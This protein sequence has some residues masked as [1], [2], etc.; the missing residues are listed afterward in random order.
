MSGAKNIFRI[1]WIFFGFPASSSRVCVCGGGGRSK[2]CCC[3]SF[4]FSIWVFLASLF[5]YGGWLL[6][7]LICRFARR[8][9]QESRR[10][11]GRRLGSTWLGII[12]T[13]TT[14]R[15]AQQETAASQAIGSSVMVTKR[16]ARRVL[17]AD[18]AVTI[19]RA[20]LLLDL[21]YVVPT[22]TTHSFLFFLVTQ[23]GRPIPSFLS[24]VCTHYATNS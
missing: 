18:T 1:V 16:N 4:L 2:E 6:W 12:F 22:T 11:G 3:S 13:T 10:P 24:P 23:I 8:T 15:E 21:R 17:S 14:T 20:P 7:L 19:R 9:G 5:V